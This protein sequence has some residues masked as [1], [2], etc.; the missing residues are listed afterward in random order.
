MP[1]C[2]IQ[3]LF[4][5]LDR[6]SNPASSGPEGTT[7]SL[8]ADRHTSHGR[9][10]SRP[11]QSII[12]SRSVQH[13]IDHHPMSSLLSPVMSCN[14]AIASN[15]SNSRFML[16]TCVPPLLLRLSIF[17]NSLKKNIRNFR[18]P[19][20]RGIHRAYAQSTA[21]LVLTEVR[22]LENGLPGWGVTNQYVL[23]QVS[24]IARTRRKNHHSSDSLKAS[25]S[26]SQWTR[27][28]VSRHQ[29]YSGLSPSAAV[30][31][32]TSEAT[33]NT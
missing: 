3:I 30:P 11:R 33:L 12:A 13:G 23:Y 29:A 14:A 1:T 22:Y 28:C 25:Y 7:C 5:T 17:K 4:K 10:S 26:G 6:V 24:V 27:P 20:L 31:A 8:T 16:R 21:H 2:N 19:S 18:N 32:A 15:V 9:E